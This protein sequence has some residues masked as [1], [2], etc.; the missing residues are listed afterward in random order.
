MDC[1]LLDYSVKQTEYKLFT[2]YY[3]GEIGSPL[4]APFQ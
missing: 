1:H 3:H 4:A 2:M